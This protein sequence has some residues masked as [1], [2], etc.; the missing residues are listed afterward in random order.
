MLEGEKQA[1]LTQVTQHIQATEAKLKRLGLP[2]IQLG[3]WDAR[4]RH[5]ITHHDDLIAMAEGKPPASLRG[6][7]VSPSDEQPAPDP[8]EDKGNGGE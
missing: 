6:V 3:L 7:T 5:P 4:T 2:H 8:G 1:L